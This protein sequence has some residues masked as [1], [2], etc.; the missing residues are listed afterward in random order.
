[1][2][3][4]LSVFYRPEMSVRNND[5]FSPSAG[6]PALVVNDWESRF[7][8]KIEI[9]PF[10]PVSP[11]QLHLVHNR[12]YVDAVLCGAIPNG[13][14]NNKRRVADATLYT[15][16]SMVAA[17]RHAAKERI[18]TCSPSSGFHH[19]GHF[20]GSGYCT[21]NGLALA[22]K[23]LLDD[24]PSMSI[25]IIDCDI[26]FGDGT[27]NILHWLHDLAGSVQHFSAGK[28]FLPGDRSHRP[29]D[30]L[31]WVENAVNKSRKCDLIIYQAGADMHRD[32]P[33]GGFLTTEM[34]AKRDINLFHAAA[35]AGVPVAWNLAGG[36]QRDDNGGIE[37][38]LKIHR[39]TLRACLATRTSRKHK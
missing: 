13:F 38:V 33:L 20:S 15:C 4:K 1:M 28:T 34:M 7:G 3:K 23:L 16:G 10:E 2:L 22:C 26:H 24:R 17:A 27:A 36:Y 6:K 8:E 29:Q 5:S 31:D 19:A 11:E 35:A 12:F 32:D 21:F 37:P 9:V 25:S 14:G 30:L 39:N 18:S